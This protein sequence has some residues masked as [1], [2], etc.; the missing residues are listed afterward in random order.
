MN[1]IKYLLYTG[2][3]VLLLLLLLPYIWNLLCILFFSSNISVF[4]QFELYSWVAIGI[5][6]APFLGRLVK[7]NVM[8][9]ETFSHEFTLIVFRAL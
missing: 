8:W 4:A 9:F 3:L 7:S 2:G 5:I 6:M 1:R